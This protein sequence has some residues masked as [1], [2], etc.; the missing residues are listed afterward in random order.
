MY[1]LARANE[2]RFGGMHDHTSIK[3]NCIEV[4][5]ICT[6]I[7]HSPLMKSA[8]APLLTHKT[9]FDGTDLLY[10]A[11]PDKVLLGLKC[12]QNKEQ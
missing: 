9:N 1:D 4:Q 7:G 11:I 5:V 12:C 2:N 3:P 10:L 6:S 8:L